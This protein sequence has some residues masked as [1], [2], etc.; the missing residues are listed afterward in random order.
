MEQDGAAETRYRFG[1]VEVDVRRHLVLRGGVEL[2]LEPK[3]HA[4]LVELL[5][6]AGDVVARDV[7]LDAVWGHRHVTPAVLNR[8]VA[9][10]R[11]ELG[12]DAERPRL[13]RTVHGVG[14]AFIGTLQAPPA[15]QPSVPVPEPT[16]PIEP[17]PAPAPSRRRGF[18]AA[19]IALLAGIAAVAFVVVEREPRRHVAPAPPE[20][21][22]HSIAVL[23]LTNAT[24][25]ADQQ[26]F[27]DGLSENLITTLSQLEGLKVIGSGSS[28]RFRDRKEDAHSIGA[29]LAVDH[30]VE[31]SVQRVGDDVRIGVELVRVADG[32]AVWTQRFDRPYKDLF[33][34]QDEIA[35]AVAGA[36]QLR[37]LHGMPG[38]I[39][40]GRPVSGNLAAYNAYLKGTWYMSGGENIRK[41]IEQFAEATRLDPGYTQAWSWLG[42]QRLMYANRA[43]EGE[44]ARAA[45]AQVREDIDTALRLEPDFGQAH[46]VRAN[47]L[48]DADYDWSGALAEFRIALPLV[49]DTDPVHG[50]LS[51]LLATL[52]RIDEAIA[53]R[54][55]YI[56]GDPLA[57]F[58]RIYLAELLASLG[59]LDEAEASLRDAMALDPSANVRGWL[60][61][62]RSWVA[63]L[64][65]DAVVAL[66][67]AESMAPGLWRD[68]A[69]ALAL[70]IG[71][72]R[73]AADVALQRV[74]DNEARSKG[75]AYAI[76][77]IHALRGDVDQAFEWLQRDWERGGGG[78]HY[79]LFDPFLLRLREDARFARY[80]RQTGLP[81]PEASEALSLERIRAVSAGRIAL[82]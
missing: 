60:V 81:T 17:A 62:Q 75:G 45:Y 76:A 38:A 2:S 54:R 80:C 53:E 23:P 72:D 31:G 12:D 24:G 39:D 66:R 65:S 42:F 10:L 64:R 46:G 56:E 69:I 6:R 22:A 63:I 61:A 14:Y 4:V 16:S 49:P 32:S 34:L 82:P 52:G 55:K 59:R 48:S 78:V 37:V 50:A 3:A 25:A 7:L 36:L 5:C 21:T 47:V 35:L 29:K 15:D 43:L 70:Q 8:I 19:V 57:G 41:A 20:I 79:V 51:R 33:A 71:H 9:I 73:S 40:T 11:R 77:R 1:D 27:S 28:F 18:V 68:R 67:E 58:A 13:I 44:A 30:L 74:V 26:F